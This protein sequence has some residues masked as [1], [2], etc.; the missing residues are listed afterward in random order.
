MR[1]S[2]NLIFERG[3]DSIVAR[4]SELFKTQQQM[5]TGRRVLTPADDPVAATLALR[6][7]QGLSLT[8]QQAVNQEAAV[9]TLNLTDSAT[10][11]IGDVLQEVRQLLVASGNGGYADSDRRSLATEL[12]GRLQQ[13]A[14]LANARDGA[15]GYLFAGFNDT[16]PPFG[17]TST[18]ASYGGDDGV[19]ELEVAPQRQLAVSTN[20]STMLMR[21]PSGNGVFAVSAAAGN[22][23]TG[24]IDPGRVV[25]PAALTGHQYRL[26]FTGPASFDVLDLTT[27]AT[28]SSANSYTSGTAIG[29]AGMQT[30]I[31]GSPAAGDTFD[32]APSTHQS[33][34]TTFVNAI[35]ALNT[36]AS[37]P[38]AATAIANQVSRAI[39]DLDR[40]FDSVLTMRTGIGV[41]LAE[42]DT[43]KNVTSGADNE[44][45]RRLSELQD[46]DYAK[47][48]SDL[49]RQ[50]TLLQADQ[51][52][53]AKIAKLSLFDYL[54]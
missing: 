40:A 10:G 23:G 52:S 1:L 36:P 32:L 4:Q 26:V 49:A 5:A 38:A 2:T 50:Q 12:S 54:A 18:G 16:A 6:T 39:T 28:V 53:F 13:L 51:Q 48:A 44:Q 46:L 21:V 19:R 29:V 35:A 15:S 25:T 7:Q 17:L 3:T 42:L 45:Q 34:F 8:R 22:S 24:L 41:K 27:A 31:T 20:G 43:L 37:T 9:S 11:S 14:G 30:A 47:A 33:V